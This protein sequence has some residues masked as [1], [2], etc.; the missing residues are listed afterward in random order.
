MVAFNK[1]N[2]E[3]SLDGSRFK[4]IT[5][6]SSQGINVLTGETQSLQNIEIPGRSTIIVEF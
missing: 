3:I 6:T 4:E 1:N 5:G 2:E